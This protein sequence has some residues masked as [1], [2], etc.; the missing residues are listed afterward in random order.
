MFSHTTNNFVSVGCIAWEDC[1][2]EGLL[3]YFLSL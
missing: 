1:V 2:I 3:L